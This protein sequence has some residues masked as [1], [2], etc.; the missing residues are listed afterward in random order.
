M[1]KQ[2]SECISQASDGLAGRAENAVRILKFGENA[3]RIFK[4]GIGFN[5]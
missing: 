4:F 5:N 1:M 3:V 2:L